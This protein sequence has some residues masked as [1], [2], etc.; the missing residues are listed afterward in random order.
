M[1]AST[2]DTIDLRAV[3]RK[4]R[5][6]WWWFL[7]SV[8]FCMALALF[9]LKTTPKRYE[10]HSV[11]LLGEK[12]RSGFGNNEEFIKGHPTWSNSSDMEDKIAMLTSNRMMTSTLKRL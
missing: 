7:L 6:K 10:V 8:P 12:K 11:M 9:Y 2:S 3:F 1:S 4:V 5:A